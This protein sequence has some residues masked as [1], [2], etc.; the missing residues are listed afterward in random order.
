MPYKEVNCDKC[1]GSGKVTCPDCHGEGGY[2]ETS[3]GETEW[4]KCSY[5]DGTGRTRCDNGCVWGKKQVW[6]D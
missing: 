3:A 2:S 6:V 1:G 5:C 4:K